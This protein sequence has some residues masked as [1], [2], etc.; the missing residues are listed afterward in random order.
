MSKR[1]LMSA[2][3]SSTPTLR[4]KWRPVCNACMVIWK[5]AM[6]LHYVCMLCQLFWEADVCAINV[7]SGQTLTACQPMQPF[8]GIPHKAGLM[9]WSLP[10][11]PLPGHILPMTTA[12]DSQNQRWWLLQHLCRPEATQWCARAFHQ[13]WRESYLLLCSTAFECSAAQLGL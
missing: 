10:I 7:L 2:I 8:L 9:P 1:R 12:W 11:C 6:W 13:G 3:Y 5:S 4:A